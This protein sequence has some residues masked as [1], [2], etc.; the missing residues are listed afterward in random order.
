MM[1]D[2]SVELAE[3]PCRDLRQHC[4]FERNRLAHHD[5]EG[6]HAI[7]CYKKDTLFVDGINVAH[8]PPPEERERK[9]SR[10]DEHQTRISLGATGEAGASASSELTISERNSSTCC[11][12]RPMNADGSAASSISLRFR[13]SL[14]SWARRSSKSFDMAPSFIA[15]DAAT[16]WRRIISCASCRSIP[17][18]TA[19]SISR[20]VAMN[21]SSD[22]TRRAI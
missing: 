8:F 14:P 19:L 3:P 20:S 1:T 16:L 15:L 4:A 11:G 9:L 5:V 10:C 13:P 2:A 7:G 6:A 18:R 12:A 21:G 22:F 17:F